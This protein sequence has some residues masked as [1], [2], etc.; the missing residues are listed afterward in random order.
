MDNWGLANEFVA[1][2]D[3]SFKMLCLHLLEVAYCEIRDAQSVTCEW[4]ENAIT[5]I[6][7]A[8]MEGNP[9]SIQRFISVNVE[10]RLLDVDLF[11]VTSTVDDAPRIDIMIGGFTLSPNLARVH[12]YIEAKNLYCQDFIK[13]GNASKT[14]ST[15]YA[16]RYIATGIDNLLNGH[17]PEETLL[18]GYVLNGTIQGAV[19]KINVRLV[20]D[21]R[22]N[23]S[24]STFFVQDFSH[25]VLGVSNHPNGMVLEH[26][27]LQF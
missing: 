6:L 12:Y 2:A 13:S 1:S 25:L 4:D 9:E 27:F 15:T 11:S 21:N 8:R 26:C 17:Y 20:T 7:G 14:S 23:E 16:K 10:K 22:K 19:D 18:L 5:E 3:T 24:V